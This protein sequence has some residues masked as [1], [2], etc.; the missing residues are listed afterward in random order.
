MLNKVK[1][2]FRN[3]LAVEK[4][5]IVLYRKM[6]ERRACSKTRPFPYAVAKMSRYL[7]SFIDISL[8]TKMAGKKAY[9]RLMS[10]S[11]SDD[12]EPAKGLVLSSCHG[13]L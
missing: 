5:M 6:Q 4:F 13:A 12:E 10:P 7:K 8:L 2:C 3:N 1:R 9:S 11:L